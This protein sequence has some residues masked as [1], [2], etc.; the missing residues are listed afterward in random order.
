MTQNKKVIGVTGGIGSGK[1]TICEYFGK[2]GAYILDADK[3]GHNVLM[4]GQEA[5][6]EVFNFFG[7]DILDER[8]EINRHKLAEIVFADAQ[9]LD[10]LEQITHKYIKQ[11]IAKEIEIC[12]NSVVVLEAIALCESGS[13]DMCD[14][15]VA[16]RAPRELRISRIMTRDN[17]SEE[18][19]MARVNSQ[20]AD[21]YYVQQAT[22]V[23][24]TD[25]SIEDVREDVRQLWERVVSCGK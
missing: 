1:S 21:E 19:A 9:K 24:N 25:K 15:I 16:V 17:L 11:D 14:V 3:V 8:G 18:K 23:L 10:A 4:R 5:H 20:K 22:F 7:K 13:A 2:L 12:E 6:N